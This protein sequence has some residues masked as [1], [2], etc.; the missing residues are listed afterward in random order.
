V[1]KTGLPAKKLDQV[2]TY[3]DYASWPNDERWELIDGVAWN[4]SP[5]PVRRHQKILG[6]LYMTFREYFEEKP[7]EVYLAPFDV[8]FPSGKDEEMNDVTTVVQP[9]LSVI[10]DREKLVDKGC[11]GPP[12]L[13]VEILSPY[14]SKKDLN[15]KF[16]LFERSGVYEY[17]V[18]DPGN[19]YIRAFK[20]QQSGEY[21]PGEVFEAGDT[22]SSSHFAGLRVGVDALVE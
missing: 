3:K 20:L 13:V 17:W 18:I 16:R 9:D 11:F 14:T 12:D 1:K 7:C 21:D 8:F 22:A 2:Y 5:A 10:C 15:E 19:K 4:M 6:N